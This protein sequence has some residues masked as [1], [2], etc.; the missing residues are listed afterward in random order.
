[1]NYVIT[2][3]SIGIIIVLFAILYLAKPSIMIS[4]LEFF[5]KGKRLYLPGILRFILAIIFLLG[6]NRCHYPAV[7]AVFGV[8]FIIG[9][10]LIFVMKLEKLKSILDWW[11]KQ[12]IVLLRVLAIITFIIGA[13]IVY[14]A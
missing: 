10:L 7:I 11:Q 3:K 5:K 6:A 13:V 12:S 4:I 14:S 2:I 9:G 1:M 8:M